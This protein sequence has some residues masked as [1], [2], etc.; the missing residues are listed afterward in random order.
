MIIVKSGGSSR[1]GCTSGRTTRGRSTA[2]SQSGAYETLRAVLAKGDPADVQEQV[3]ISGLRGRGGANFST[4]QKWSFLPADL[5]PRYLVVNGDEGEPSTFKDRMLVERDPHQLVEGIIIS[6]FAIQCNQAF[7]YLRGEF[8][9]GYDRLTRALDDARA[10]RL[11]RQEHPR[12]GLRPRDRRAPRRG[13]VHL[14]RGDRA[15]RVA[16][17]RARDAAAEAAV[18]RDRRALRQADRGQQRRDALDGSAHREDGRRRVRRD[19]RQQVD[20]HARRR[21]LGSREEAGQL[22][23]RV[24]LHVPRRDLRVRGRDPRRSHAQV[25]PA[26][27]RVV[28]VARRSRRAPRRDLRHRLRA[29]ERSARR[30]ARAR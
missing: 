20:R 16:R 1:S 22:R 12:L 10:K 6:A 13:R 17:G 26:R 18:P 30:S 27:R 5:F 8:A 2:R 21:D 14:R 7:V 11:P 19:R 29:A 24:R 15:D 28:P 3:K 9:L 25:L 4:G 23:D